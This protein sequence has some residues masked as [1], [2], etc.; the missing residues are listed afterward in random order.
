MKNNLIDISS[1]K[2]NYHTING[3]IKAIDDINLKV[4]EHDVIAILGPSGSGKSTLLSIICGL[5]K[6]SSGSIIKRDNL[7]ISYM[8]QS[9]SLFN[10]LTIY[11]NAILG[12]RIKKLLDKEHLDYVD[13]LFKFYNLD[14]FKDKYPSSLSGGMRQ[15]VL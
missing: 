7:S 3:E 9:D 2:K 14:D 13:Y 12:L 10:H 6:E 4:K 15:R 5:D 11:E 8:L 1:L